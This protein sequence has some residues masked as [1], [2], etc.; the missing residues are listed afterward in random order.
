MLDIQLNYDS[1][2]LYGEFREI[3]KKQQPHSTVYNAYNSKHFP[4]FLW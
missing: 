4:H 3:P 1:E 2:N